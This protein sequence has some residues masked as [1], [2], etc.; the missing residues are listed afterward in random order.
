[1]RSSIYLPP[2]TYIYTVVEEASLLLLA[3][4]QIRAAPSS[5][6]ALGIFLFTKHIDQV[7]LVTVNRLSTKHTLIPPGDAS[8]RGSS[9]LMNEFPIQWNTFLYFT[10]CK[11]IWANTQHWEQQ[12]PL[13]MD[14]NHQLAY[15]RKE[16]FILINFRNMW[17]C[18][19]QTMLRAPQEFVQ[20]NREHNL[21]TVGENSES[22]S[23][24]KTIFL[25]HW[26]EHQLNQG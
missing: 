4:S 3:K 7:R 2:I 22:V 23:R 17:V 20:V 1:M 10:S 11:G 14:P 21:D 5:A 25:A 12:K 6:R 13:N 8:I 18:H 19:R 26:G 16:G 24:G 9:L 15:K